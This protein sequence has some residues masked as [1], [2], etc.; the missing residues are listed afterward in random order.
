MHELYDRGST[1]LSEYEA[2]CRS[3]EPQALSAEQAQELGI[4]VPND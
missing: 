2:Q 1:L 4:E 3:T